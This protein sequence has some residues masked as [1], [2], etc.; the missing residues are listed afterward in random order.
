[1]KTQACRLNR[2]NFETLES[3]TMLDA[4][5]V[6]ALGGAAHDRL[7]DMATDAAGNSYVV[8]EFNAAAR[9][10]TTNLTPA[11]GTDV[12][13]TKLNPIGQV[14]WATRAGGTGADLG[15][16][17]TVDSNGN[18]IVAGYF[19]G[20]AKFGNKTLVSAGGTD[21]FV[22]MLAG[23]NGS[24][25]W[26]NKV[27]GSGNDRALA[28]EVD[29]SNN[30]YISGGLN[31]SNFVY[32]EGLNSQYGSTQLF[33][34]KYKANGSQQWTKTVSG[35][36]A[37]AS[38]EGLALDN[39]GGVYVAGAFSGTANFTTGALSSTSASRD[40]LVAKLNA[41][42]G[43]WQWAETVPTTV[44]GDI[45]GVAYLANHLYVTGAFE[46]TATFDAHALTSAGITDG[47]IASFNS[48][49]RSFDWAQRFGGTGLDIAR[50]LGTDSQGKIHVVGSYRGTADFGSQTLVNPAPEGTTFITA[51][52]SAGAFVESLSL[53]GPGSN[54]A[55][56]IGFDGAGNRYVGGYF[57]EQAQFPQRTLTSAGAI[58]SYV[59][60]L[61]TT[62]TPNASRNMPASRAMITEAS[63]PSKPGQRSVLSDESV[64]EAA[65]ANFG[66]Q[67]SHLL[68]VLI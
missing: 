54:S 9:F 34:N 16:S 26:A 30:I 50:E 10:G 2:L 12:F 19:S 29:S 53:A 37:K 25:Q 68:L 21:A 31:G 57:E 20:T 15:Y 6:A 52:T 5:W 17:V 64:L 47:F 8:G 56:N 40:L 36:M 60:K 33:V 66:D 28:V 27:G 13:I 3:R 41:S 67:R 11:G 18:V 58:D 44:D 51:L 48:A 61:G 35:N 45:R 49:T 59:T 43:A 32:A 1:M 46:G 14:L 7:W 4:G 65:F 38:F 62:A 22:A 42:N 55:R 24:F 63:V 23:N 39:A